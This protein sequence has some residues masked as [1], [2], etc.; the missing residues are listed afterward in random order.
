MRLPLFLLLAASLAAADT[1]VLKGGRK[2]Q[3]AIVSDD[4]GEVVVNV[5][6]STVKGVE[7]GTERFPADKV[8]QV[9][10]TFPLPHQ[11]FQKRLR[12]CTGAGTLVELAQWAAERKLKEEEQYALELALRADPADETARKLLGSR[13]PK[14]DW[15]AQLALAKRYLEDEDPAEALAGIRQ[16]PHFPWG[17]RYLQR[18]RRSVRQAQG[19]QRDRPVAVRAD[20]LRENARY[21]LVVPKSYDPLRP[22]PLVIGLHGGGAGGA[23]GKL[24]VG[25]GYEAMNFYQF[26]CEERGWI[27]A[28]PTALTAGWGDKVNDELIDALLEELFAL[29]NVDLHRI[30]LVGHSMGGGG[31]WQQGSRLP[32]TWAAVAPAA[33]FGVAGIDQLRKTGTGMYVYHSDDDPRCP[34]DGV[35]P[36]MT[37][38]PG[39]DADFV[40]TELPRRGHDFPGEVVKDIFDFFELRLLATKRGRYR[41]EVRPLSSFTLKVSRD[42][43]KYLPALEEDAGGEE[44]LAAL[45]RDLRTGGGVAEQAAAKLVALDDPRTSASVAKVLL[46]PNTGS[47]VRLYA[48][49]VLGGRKARDQLDTLGRALLVEDESAALLAMLGAVEQIG[50]PLAGDALIKFLRKRKAFLDRRAGGSDLDHSDW[51]TILPPMA[52]ACSLLGSYKTDKAAPAICETVLE[53]VFLAGLRVVYDKENQDPLHAARALAEAACGA[54][55]ALADPAAV[56]SLR[57]MA[58]AAGTAGGVTVDTRYRVV[59]AMGDWAR[60]PAIA[61]HAREA[62][63]RLQG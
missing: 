24:V 59:G 25:N 51:A 6:N 13:A 4:Q 14:G 40:Y 62:L 49:R 33:S 31:T 63:G 53:G 35:R 16:D 50:D 55:G 18:A 58:E 15:S 54:L 29:Y 7:F 21:T 52:Q 60:D 1:V 11:E 47:D 2:V 20:Q 28:C 44:T 9:I 39:T 19:Y 12:Q 22:T 43:K 46:R 8:K 41:P 23:D 34:V 45:L 26:H 36:A 56:P 3:G 5:Y 37:R 57:R 38:L 10:R 30:Y 32:E 42:E 27:C 48:A 61:G 17:E